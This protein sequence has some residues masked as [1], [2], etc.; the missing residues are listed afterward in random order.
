MVAVG[1]V[2]TVNVC[3]GSTVPRWGGTELYVD[4]LG[5]NRDEVVSLLAVSSAFT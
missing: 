3:A 2:V 1:V 5:R 4:G